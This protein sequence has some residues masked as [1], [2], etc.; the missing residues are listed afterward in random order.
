M[1][2]YTCTICNNKFKRY[3]AQ[4]V[5]KDPTCSRKCQAEKFKISE[6]YK[7]KNNPNYK[8]GKCVKESYCSCGK[9]KDYRA[10][11]CGRCSK[12][13]KP[14]DVTS[15]ITDEQIIETI[16]N[17]SNILEVAKKTGVS[18]GRVSLLIKLKNIPIDH[19]QPSSYRPKSVSKIFVIGKKRSSVVRRRII[20]DGLL[21]YKCLKCGLTDRW[22]GEPLTLDLDHINGNRADNRLENLRFL[23]PNCH[24]QTPTSRGRNSKGKKKTL[25]NDSNN[26]II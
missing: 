7:G 13:S 15:W 24:T 6:Q 21:P 5:V 8:D 26:H 12:R 22:N 20:K 1:K 9:L 4:V 23:C 3:A 19:F 11:R 25:T 17:C 2:E 16:K 18:A 14:K 10:E